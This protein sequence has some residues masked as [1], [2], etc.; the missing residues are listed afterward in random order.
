MFLA[1]IGH[2]SFY[3]LAGSNEKS[4]PAEAGAPL[5]YSV[6]LKLKFYRKLQL[7]G[8]SRVAGWEAGVHNYSH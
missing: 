5:V 1:A 7:A 6:Q 3:L 8:R 2:E 4:A